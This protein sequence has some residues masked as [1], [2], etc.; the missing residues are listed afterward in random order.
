MSVNMCVSSKTTR[1]IKTTTIICESVVL[2]QQQMVDETLFSTTFLLDFSGIPSFTPC[3]KTNNKCVTHDTMMISWVVS[4]SDFLSIV[5]YGKK[6]S[7]LKSLSSQTLSHQRS[8]SCICVCFSLSSQTCRET[9]VKA[10]KEMKKGDN[11]L[12]QIHLAWHQA[13]STQWFSQS[14]SYE[15][16]LVANWVI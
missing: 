6:G 14:A 3:H 10:G 2:H 13:C 4:I 16:P 15:E 1:N 7:V 8:I 11:V 5:K 12:W 9:Q